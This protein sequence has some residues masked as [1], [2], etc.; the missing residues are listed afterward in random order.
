MT[1][2]KVTTYPKEL[3]KAEWKSKKKVGT[4]GGEPPSVYALAQ[5][6]INT[7]LGEALDKAQVAWNAID[8]N[9]LNA[10]TFNPREQP[11]GPRVGIKAAL[12]KAVQQKNGPV[13]NAADKLKAA[14]LKADAAG[15][16]K[17]LSKQ[18]NT[19]ATAI[20]TKLQSQVAVLESITLDD[21]DAEIATWEDFWRGTRAAYREG[22]QKVSDKVAN[23]SGERTAAGWNKANILDAVG[24]VVNDVLKNVARQKMTDLM[25]Y[26]SSW[27]RIITLTNKMNEDFRGTAQVS[28]QAITAYINAVNEELR[29]V[30]PLA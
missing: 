24:T 14:K 3:T 13:K 28:D 7:G 12:V 17:L 9:Q 30:P 15:K 22:F 25:A 10:K 8:W 23:F 16:H 4:V 11:D 1:V 21:F 5:A 26:G 20:A 6:K 27:G 2:P 18:A 19:A 29:K